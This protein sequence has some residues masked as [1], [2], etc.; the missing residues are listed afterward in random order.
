[1]KHACAADQ[2]ITANA[3]AG[4]LRQ[5]TYPAGLPMSAPP[6]PP[7]LRSAL[8]MLPPPPP[9]QQQ[10]Q[11]QHLGFTSFM[12]YGLSCAPLGSSD[13]PAPLRG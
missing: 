4:M 12:D 3:L 10:Q 7:A 2:L 9:P 6:P 5:W 11:Q 8:H 1:M 13:A